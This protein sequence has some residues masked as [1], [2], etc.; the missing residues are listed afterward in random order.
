MSLIEKIHIKIDAYTDNTF[1]G[2][3]VDVVLSPFYGWHIVKLECRYFYK[4]YLKNN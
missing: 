4:R 2:D 3:L 1:I